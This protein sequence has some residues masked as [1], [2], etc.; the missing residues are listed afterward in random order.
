MEYLE[1]QSNAGVNVGDQAGVGVLPWYVVNTKLHQE[2]SA[3]LNL[4]A[5]GVETFCPCVKET[6]IIRR[7]RQTVTG[8]LFPGYFFV[9]FNIDDQ[10]R[11]VVYARGIRNLVAFGGISSIVDETV[12]ETIKSRL[13]N[14]YLVV[15]QPTFMPGQVVRIKEGSL[16]GF[17][18]I[19]ER[20]MSG[21][22]RAAVLL[23]TVAYQARAIVGLDQIANV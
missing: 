22:Q 3:E 2:G 16:C 11:A 4:R 23:S 10:Y 14:G 12:I 19:F 5:L 21:Q 13:D 7:K 17:M 1:D 18:A 15:R 20:E 9:R 8:P 6:K